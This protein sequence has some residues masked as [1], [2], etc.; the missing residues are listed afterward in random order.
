MPEP[1]KYRGKGSQSIIGLS[2]GSPMEELDKGLKEMKGFETHRE[3]NNINQPDILYLPGT[4]A[5]TNEYT[6]RNSWLQL[7]MKQ[8]MALSYIN[9]RRGP[10]SKCRAW[11]Q[12]WVGQWKST[13][14]VTGRARMGLGV[15]GGET[16]KRANI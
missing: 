10:W 1:D 13:L 14:I 16:E 11:K 12:E 15:S 8:R 3:N 5:T 7:H 2:I 4:K 6:C 9:E